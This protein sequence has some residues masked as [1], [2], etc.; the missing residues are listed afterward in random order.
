MN[1]KN[2]IE[3]VRMNMKI[4]E[5]RPPVT[6]VGMG[7]SPGPTKTESSWI[8][9]TWKR[10][11]AAFSSAQGL[12]SDALTPIKKVFSSHVGETA[13]KLADQRLGWGP[14]SSPAVEQ[15]VPRKLFVIDDSKK[16]GIEEVPERSDEISEKPEDVPS[17]V[18]KAAVLFPRRTIPGRLCTAFFPKKESESPDYMA[19]RDRMRSILNS[20]LDDLSSSYKIPD[21]DPLEGEQLIAAMRGD[22]EDL[23]A[24][25]FSIEAGQLSVFKERERKDIQSLI[26][27][28]ITKLQNTIKNI[29]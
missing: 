26:Q 17:D 4:P 1:K 13:Q 6:E 20:S 12:I 25:S 21:G 2:S 11:N 7:S 23:Q 27:D 3:E 16:A 8:G 28:K 29:A 14:N 22:I 24:M 5:G 9:H 19:K 10:L 18:E 15:R